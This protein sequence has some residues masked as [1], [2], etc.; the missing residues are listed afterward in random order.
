MLTSLPELVRVNVPAP[1]NCN[2]LPVM[3]A[4]VPAIPPAVVLSV[5]VPAPAAMFCDSVKV[6]PV[7]KV[8]LPPPVVETPT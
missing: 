3:A 5:T 2:L 1:L 7:F 8:M 4:A 6:F